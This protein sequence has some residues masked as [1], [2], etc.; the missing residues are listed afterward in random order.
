MSFILLYI[1]LYYIALYYILY[2]SLTIRDTAI[3]TNLII[4]LSHH[5]HFL[6]TLFSFLFHFI[7]LFRLEKIPSG[8]TARRPIPCRSTSRS[9]EFLLHHAGDSAHGEGLGRYILFKP[10]LFISTQ[11]TYGRLRC[12]GLLKFIFKRRRMNIKYIG[13][14]KKLFVFDTAC[15]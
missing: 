2:N 8:F 9:S 15:V 4:P 3:I 5:S 13:R 10:L 6:S 12:K 7:H 1:I 11:M 14:T